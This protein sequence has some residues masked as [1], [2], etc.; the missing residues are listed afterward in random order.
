MSAV[1]EQTGAWLERFISQ[2]PALAWMQ[3]LRDAAFARF[4]ALGFP[5]THNEEWRFTN[6]SAIARTAFTPVAPDALLVY[7]ESVKQLEPAQAE[8]HLA[9][10]AAFDRN[11][12]VALNTAFLGNVVVL[13]IPRNAVIAQPIE[14]TYEGTNGAAAHPRILILVGANA[15]CTIVETYKGTGT[16]FT[17]AVTEIVVGD[18][19]VVDHY[20][21]QQESVSTYHIATLQATIGRSATFASHS[22]SLGGA[23]V[24]N[25]V[26]ATL[27]EGSDATLN[28][29]YIV[30]GTQHIDNHTL[31][32]HAMPHGTSHELYK[33]ILD[34]NAHAVFNGKIIVRKDAQKT[35]S[36]Q[37]NKNLVLSDNAVVD[38][39]P[40]LQIFADDVR[41]TH[42]ATIGQLDA[43]SLF[44][45]QSRG[46][47]K[48]EAR[49]LLT[50]AFAQDEVDRIKVQALRDS[51]ERVLY[52][53]FHEHAE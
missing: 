51:L 1:A 28:G 14:I 38:T 3:S 36:K 12:F 33:G 48:R 39:K 8:A 26:N 23:L 32:D 17:N 16:Y 4:A 42:G 40:E 30:N 35:D 13:D 6:V 31:I 15:Q 7:P 19:A 50:Y 10:H 24:R 27:S 52:E 2:P 21:V 9:R 43:E 18:R 49:S 46:I 44:Y 34:G 53:K 20:K 37:T 29:L 22:I 47:G 41:C 5:N 45:L 11:P 25:D